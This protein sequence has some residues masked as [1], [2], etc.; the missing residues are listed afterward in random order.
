MTNDRYTRVVLTVIAASLAVDAG[1]RVFSIR[2]AHAS[3]TI[4]CEI[5]DTVKIEGKIALDTFGNPVG[6]KI[7]ES[8]TVPVKETKY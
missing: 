1:S 3:S 6:V 5:D 7:V 2:D 4:R 8:A